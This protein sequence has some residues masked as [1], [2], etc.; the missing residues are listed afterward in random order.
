[1]S[2][3]HAREQLAKRAK[4][5]MKIPKLLEF[6]QRIFPQGVRITVELCDPI[7]QNRGVLKLIGYVFRQTVLKVQLG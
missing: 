3:L 2:I 7:A 5:S 6:L 1:M 4:R